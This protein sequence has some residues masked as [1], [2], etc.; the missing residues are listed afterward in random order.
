MANFVLLAFTVLIWGLYRRSLGD[1]L[2]I[3][4]FCGDVTH[5]DR[6]RFLTCAKG[7]FYFIP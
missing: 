7:H 4:P 2:S 1:T 5:T 3:C 6:F